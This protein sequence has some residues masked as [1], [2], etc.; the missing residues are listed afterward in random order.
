MGYPPNSQVKQALTSAGVGSVK[1]LL[2]LD[3]ELLNQLTF[4]VGSEERKLKLLDVAKLKR[5]SSFHTALCTSEAGSRISIL[6]DDLWFQTTETDW[7][8]FRVG[9]TAF[10]VRSTQPTTT[11]VAT[12]PTPVTATLPNLREAFAKSIKKDPEAYPVFK[13]A[14]LWDSWNRKLKSMWRIYTI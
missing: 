10:I 11:T 2:T 9:S 1:D 8:E 13:E 5:V 3:G 6:P 12:Q 14:R 7:D 4:T